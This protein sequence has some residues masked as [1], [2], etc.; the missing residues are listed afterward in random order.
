MAK[1]FTVIINETSPRA[2]DFLKV[3]GRREVHVKSFVPQLMEHPDFAEPQ[4]IY[5]LDFDF[6]TEEE[7]ERLTDLMSEKFQA[8]RATVSAALKALGLPI[9][10]HD[11]TIVV[12]NPQKWIDLDDAPF[13]LDE[14]NYDEDYWGDEY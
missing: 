5:L 2:A 6:V 14:D 13:D 10:A 1:D 12:E 9:L 3:F 8:A 4:P 7:F 11:C